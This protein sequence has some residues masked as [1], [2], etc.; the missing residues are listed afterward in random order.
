MFC[1][2]CMKAVMK[3][4]NCSMGKIIFGADQKGNHIH[5]YK[6][7]GW[8]IKMSGYYYTGGKD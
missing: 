2:D 4:N 6:I 3:Y 1:K 7:P 8:R 5:Y